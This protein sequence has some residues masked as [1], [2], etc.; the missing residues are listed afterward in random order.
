M[1]PFGSLSIF[2]GR[3]YFQTGRVKDVSRQLLANPKIEIVAYDGRGAW[4]RVKAVA[5]EDDR[6]EAKQHMLDQ[7]PELKAMYSADD[8]N[9]QV[10][11]LKDATASMASMGGDNWTEKF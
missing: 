2:E 11:Y 5:V 10:F 8:G 7:M 6:L 4:I 1:R 9:T 3:I